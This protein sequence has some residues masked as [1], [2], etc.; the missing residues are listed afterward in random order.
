M[1][2]GQSGPDIVELQKLLAHA[3]VYTPSG[4]TFDDAMVAAVEKFQQDNNLTKDGVVGNQTLDRLLH[5]AGISTRVVVTTVRERVEETDGRRIFEVFSNDPRYVIPRG[6]RQPAHV[7]AATL[8]GQIRRTNVSIDQMTAFIKGAAPIYEGIR[9]GRNWENNGYHLLNLFERAFGR[10]ERN[11]AVARINEIMAVTNTPEGKKKLERGYIALLE[12]SGRQRYFEREEG[13]STGEMTWNAR[14]HLNTARKILPWA[15]GIYLFDIPLPFMEKMVPSGVPMDKAFA[16]SE[17][18][19]GGMQGEFNPEAK[20]ET[21]VDTLQNLK[22]LRRMLSTATDYIQAHANRNNLQEVAGKV[23]ELIK[24][25]IIYRFG[26]DADVLRESTQGFFENIFDAL[27]LDG[28]IKRTIEAIVQQAHS[29]RVDFN[30]IFELEDMLR[31]EDN[32]GIFGIG[33]GANEQFIQAF[34]NRNAYMS[35]VQR[36]GD[37]IDQYVA[38]VVA[39]SR[40]RY[41]AV[42]AD[43]RRAAPVPDTEAKY[44]EGLVK[45]GA[46]GPVLGRDWTGE[47]VLQALQSTRPTREHNRDSIG[48]I[49]RGLRHLETDM[50][51]RKIPYEALADG[52]RHGKMVPM[53]EYRNAME[54][55]N[56]GRNG[57]V[58][59][60][61]LKNLED[62]GDTHLFHAEIQVSI[63]G[64]RMKYD[65]YLRPDCSNLVLIPKEWDNRVGVGR[66]GK[67]PVVIPW[68]LITGGTTGSGDVSTNP[69]WDDPI[70]LTDIPTGDIPANI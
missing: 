68:G 2:K 66:E 25:Y 27:G 32:D 21:G 1:R 20:V 11:R 3:T 12:S 23:R 57:N 13:N 9:N 46:Y 24:T 45:R 26:P 59:S 58:V 40:A 7:L 51:A 47:Q 10:N 30:K 48:W 69:G 33:D 60:R 62:R 61:H 49:M 34:E 39:N 36:Q 35:S 18:V 37:V 44:V 43:D 55:I 38:A 29:G 6:E 52:I 50:D 15:A 16:F 19:R 41:E 54:V 17:W 63:D 67:F 8:E 70:D 31:K 42:Q 65:L 5:V 14:R 4:D 64:R 56:T 28:E 22:G 53:S